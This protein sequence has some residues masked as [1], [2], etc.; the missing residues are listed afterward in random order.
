MLPLRPGQPE[1]HTH[2]HKRS[3]T[4]DVKTGTVIRSCRKR[5]CATEFRVFLDQVKAAVP[6]HLGVHLVLDNAA[7]H[8]TRIVHDWLDERPC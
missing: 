2:D 3:G 4:L 1:R 5:H 8:K 6:R 7:A